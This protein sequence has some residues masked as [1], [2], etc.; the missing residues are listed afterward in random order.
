MKKGLAR[1]MMTVALL[2][3]AAFPAWASG[4]VD[5]MCMDG[6][7]PEIQRMAHDMRIKVAVVDDAFSTFDV[8]IQWN[9]GAKGVLTGRV[10][11]RTVVPMGGKVPSAVSIVGLYNCIAYERHYGF[12]SDSRE[13]VVTVTRSGKSDLIGF[14]GL[15]EYGNSDPVP[16][17]VIWDSTGTKACMVLG[18]TPAPIEGAAP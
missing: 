14:A 4:W 18:Q 5:S 6:G 12:P 13:V 3:L 2:V 1:G 9:P 16:Y 8:I 15:V 17:T 7:G 11:G 10:D